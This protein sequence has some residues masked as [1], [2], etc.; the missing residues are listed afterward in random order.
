MGV[1]TEA[2]DTYDAQ[3]REKVPGEILETMRAL[4]RS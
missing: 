2:I 1:L 4:L 3:K